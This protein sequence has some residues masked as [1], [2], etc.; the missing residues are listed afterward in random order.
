MN[1]FFLGLLASVA[2]LDALIDAYNENVDNKRECTNIS[3]MPTIDNGVFD[4]SQMHQFLAA[5]A[6]ELVYFT[7]PNGRIVQ[8]PLGSLYN[9]IV[10]W[11]VV[12]STT[13]GQYGIV[14]SV[15][16]T[17]YDTRAAHP[18]VSNDAVV[19]QSI[20]ALV[21]ALDKC[22][23]HVGSGQVVLRAGAARAGGA[24]TP[25]IFL[26]DPLV[27]L[28][29]AE[30][31]G[32]DQAQMINQ[33]LQANGI[34]GTEILSTWASLDG[35]TEVKRTYPAGTFKGYVPAPVVLPSPMNEVQPNM[36][37]P[38]NAGRA[39]R[40]FQPNNMG[41]F[42]AQRGGGFPGQFGVVASNPLGGGFQIPGQNQGGMMGQPAP[43]MKP[44]TMPGAS[45]PPA[46]R[47]AT[48]P[49]QTEA[50]TE[51]EDEVPGFDIPT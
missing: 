10:S 33:V 50:K 8:L 44:F 4:G 41:G 48:P 32:A 40:G 26:N 34:N 17:Q 46:T 28:R 9:C 5:L 42:G 38:A 13:N 23:F 45:T 12:Q 35:V 24:A 39:Q 37:Q 20:S 47:T 49:P 21:H 18:I 27:V 30:A 31:L 1:P 22:G 3:P 15:R 11:Q 43:T 7:D 51:S 14:P 2:N 25:A 36:L 6:A 29:Q 19:H 16:F